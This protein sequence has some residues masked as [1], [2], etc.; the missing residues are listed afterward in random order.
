MP[1]PSVGE[2]SESAVAEGGALL[3]TLPEGSGPAVV[4][5]QPRSGHDSPPPGTT[6]S[7]DQFGY[8]FEP[9][10]SVARVGQPVRFRNSENVD[11]HVRVAHAETR[12]VVV[13]TNLLMDDSMAHSFVQ[14]GPYTVRCDIHP[15]MMAL[16]LV[17][18]HPYAAVADAAGEFRI[19]DIPPGLYDLTG[20]NIAGAAVVELGVEVSLDSSGSGLTLDTLR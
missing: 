7:I 10:L 1:E 14:P 6:I 19:E 13:N 3:G 9:Q 12:A 17:V 11:H 5:L 15:A 16:V 8:M 18:P 20:W 2:P 4:A